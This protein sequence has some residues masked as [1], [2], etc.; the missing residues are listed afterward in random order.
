[1]RLV[2]VV[3][4]LGQSNAGSQGRIYSS[5]DRAGVDS[6]GLDPAEF[7]EVRSDTRIF[8]QGHAPVGGTNGWQYVD[9]GYNTQSLSPTGTARKSFGV[10]T[11]IADRLSAETGRETWVI[12]AGG[13]GIEPDFMQSTG[14]TSL[15]NDLNFQDWNP[16]NSG[17]LVEQFAS[18][19]SQGFYDL[20][21]AGYIPNIKGIVWIQ[22][23][24]DAQRGTEQSSYQPLEEALL[25]GLREHIGTQNI[26]VLSTLLKTSLNNPWRNVEAVNSAKRENSILVDNYQIVE[27]ENLSFHDTIHYGTESIVELGESIAESL[28]EFNSFLVPE[29]TVS[30]SNGNVLIAESQ[31]IGSPNKQVISETDSGIRIT[32]SNHIVQSFRYAG[33]LVS[34]FVN[35]P[36]I[37]IPGGLIE[38]EVGRGDDSVSAT[39]IRYKT[40]MRGGNGNDQLTGGKNGD[41]LYGEHGDDSLI[42]GGG[43]DRLFGQVGNDFLSGE[44]GKDIIQGGAGD[45]TIQGDEGADKLLGGSGNDTIVGG[46]GQDKLWG[47]SGSD[48]F[49]YSAVD[50]SPVGATFRDKIF[51]FSSGSDLIDLSSID[52]NESTAGNQSFSFQ[53]MGGLLGT[54]QELRFQHLGANTLISGSV[55][56]SGADFQ[57]QLV[58]NI[59]LTSADFVL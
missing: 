19:V 43:A 55:N 24:T 44:S 57:I 38:V 47:N 1:M 11:I 2:D 52:A 49:K 54:A 51:D 8:V 50:D 13:G 17:E 37:Y 33:G 28:L 23:E 9:P 58:G 21:E 30:R 45:D 6:I 32:D 14:G 53:G 46:F 59:N 27:T 41:K 5:G 35:I 12:K 56:G 4:V 34:S 26:P 42:G 15:A 22:G 7:D 3:L 39:G 20:Y 36:S 31:Y 40:L 10:E 25:V 29:V 48:S 16:G 18:L